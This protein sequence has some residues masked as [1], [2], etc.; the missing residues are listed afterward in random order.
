MLQVL[1]HSC[2]LLFYLYTVLQLPHDMTDTV[3]LCGMRCLRLF[4]CGNQDL[5]NLPP[6][7]QFNCNALLLIIALLRS[8]VL[9]WSAVWYVW[10]VS[11]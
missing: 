9:Y 6:R 5:C 10:Y 4:G 3:Y 1:Q 2:K 8:G 11:M 7:L